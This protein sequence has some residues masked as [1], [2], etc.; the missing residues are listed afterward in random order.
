M[1][2]KRKRVVAFIILSLLLVVIGITVC[3]VCFSKD[4]NDVVNDF[5][6]NRTYIEEESN[7]SES[8][9]YDDNYLEEETNEDIKNDYSEEDV[10]IYFEAMEYEIENSTYFKERFKEYFI[11]V[12]DFI[13]YNNEIKGYTF[14]ELTGIAKARIIAIALKIDTK[15]ERHA[16]EYKE[17]GSDSTGKVYN[18][19]KEKLVTSYM[20]ISIIICKDNVV[21][22]NKVKD[23][24]GDVK[25]YCKIGWDFIKGLLK[26][27]LN[28][29]KDW[30]EIYSG[31]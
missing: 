10:V 12:I 23:I 28:K 26:N 4:D 17:K 22:C 7:S 6:D 31:K 21:D 27:G 8:M 13:F 30:Y 20:D 2:I 1:K 18:D 14:D 11:T 29:I 24:F 5:D 25:E 3:I 19:I 16:P 15:I 9:Y